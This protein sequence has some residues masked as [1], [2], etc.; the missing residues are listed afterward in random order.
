[1]KKNTTKEKK[2][3]NV[4]PVPSAGEEKAQKRKRRVADSDSPTGEEERTKNPLDKSSF[5]SKNPVDPSG[6]S[7]G[8]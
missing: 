4:E 6:T 2:V 1:M 3:K 7:A 8:Y 5:D